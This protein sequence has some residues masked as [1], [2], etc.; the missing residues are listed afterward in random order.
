[1]KSKAARTDASGLRPRNEEVETEPVREL[2]GHELSAHAVPRGVEPRRKRASPPLPGAT[3]TIP[4]LI[5]LLPG[6]PT[7]RSQS[8]DVSTHA[9]R[10]STSAGIDPGSRVRGCRTITL[11]G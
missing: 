6:S 7:S 1:M 9:M 5:P 2:G 3:V 4:P 10:R 11:A 8:P